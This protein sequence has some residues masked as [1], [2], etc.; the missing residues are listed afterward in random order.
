MDR[1]ISEEFREYL[2]QSLDALSIELNQAH[3]D[4]DTDHFYYRLE[5]LIHVLSRFAVTHTLP[6]E[7][8]IFTKL[9]TALL[10]LDSRSDF[11]WRTQGPNNY[12]LVTKQQI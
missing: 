5:S 7:E 1:P 4:T 11:V 3:R 9:N 2:L 6:N 8:A 10:E 12:V